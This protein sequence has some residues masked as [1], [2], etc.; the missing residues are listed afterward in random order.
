MLSDNRALI[1]R[2]AH[3]LLFLCICPTI[4]LV[5]QP[6]V[7]VQQAFLDLS[8]DGALMNVS[9]HPDDE[10][11]ASLAYYRMKH[12]VKTY[13][14]FFTRG[15]GGQNEKGPEL[16]EE[17]G[18]L[19]TV[20]TEE[21]AK[22][23][24]SE[25]VFLNLLDFGFS[26]TA[27]ETFGKWGGQQEVLRRLVYVIR[28]YKP[29]V[30]M[31]NHSTISGHG[32]HQAVAV[33]LIAAFDAANDSTFFPDQ[34]QRQGISLWQV[35]K[36]FFREFS[37]QGGDVVNAIEEVNEPR[38]ESYL[39][40]AAKALK[41]HKT[42]GL[43]RA[44]LRRFTRGKSVYKLVRESSLFDRDSTTFFSGI[45]FWAA[46]VN[47]E[48]ANLHERITMLSPSM[49]TNILLE[50]ISS[51]L[52]RVRSIRTDGG[53]APLEQRMLQHQRADLQRL[54]E[55]ICRVTISL[56]FLDTAV[57]PGQMVHCKL[58]VSSSE[59]SLSNLKYRFTLPE[60][61]AVSES[62]AMAP[63]MTP[64]RF[65]KDF[66][67]RVGSIV[68]FSLPKVRGQYNPIEAEQN[69][70]VDVSYSL[71]GHPL[72]LMRKAV[73][74]I[75]PP[76][77]LSITPT[78][79]W[80]SPRSAA[81]GKPFDV[82]VK[83]FLPRKISGT[84]VVQLPGGWRADS[85][86]FVIGREDGVAIG[87]ITVSAPRA[88]Q[89]GEY[90]IRFTTEHT[91]EDVTVRVF[92]VSVPRGLKIGI[93][94]SY[95]NTLEWALEEFE[96]PYQLLDEKALST[97]DLM[98]F[99]TIIVDIRAYLVREDLGKNNDRLL[100][101]A[102][103]GGNLVV[104]YQRDQEWKREYA[105]HPFEISRKRI[106]VE[107]A[108]IRILEPQHPLLNLPNSIRSEDWSGWI[109]E[110]ALYVPTNVAKEYV[111]LL[112]SNDPDEPPLTTGYIVATV[113]KGSYIY[114]SFVWYR[115]LKEMNPGAYRCFA[116]MISYPVYRN[117]R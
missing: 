63:D 68:H 53:V 5:A 21:A 34:L 40:I 76:Q 4:L 33:T 43:D 9:A 94:K 46:P 69:V 44:D 77:L 3:G 10:D 85:L 25:V 116:N 51:L 75:A 42:Q 92:D 61:W 114:S 58:Q 79:A 66:S 108:P 103:R 32:H 87:K 16:Y 104:M 98:G 7:D 59:C 14:I 13:S 57:V 84:V 80:I 50:N 82:V 2:V 31:T 30:I 117:G 86:P 64:Q 107:D 83:S 35:K 48:L 93:V 65:D 36:L 101:Y 12:G 20:E 115:Q 74:D 47:G 99:N 45:D 60:E 23:L 52:K 72:T 113:G 78:S 6:S 37:G 96:V 81:K 38:T 19:R 22:I 110:R 70:S 39:D 111:R 41:M 91:F 15:E 100:E 106:T 28:K 54:A 89:S 29:D 90:K 109:Q 18:A 17:L 8:H 11:G 26:K 55:T 112:A 73:F 71:N 88:V 62:K 56:Q 102:R 1:L 97:L 95:D 67:L 105:P 49:S 27:T 24:A